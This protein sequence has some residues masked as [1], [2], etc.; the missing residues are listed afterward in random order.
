[1]AVTIMAYIIRAKTSENGRYKINVGDKFVSGGQGISQSFGV[2]QIHKDGP[3]IFANR[4]ELEMNMSSVGNRFLRK[5]L[6]K[7]VL[8]SLRGV[9]TNYHGQNMLR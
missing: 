8:N 6:L 7:V 5:M 3:I 1:M 9:M 2:L 4:H